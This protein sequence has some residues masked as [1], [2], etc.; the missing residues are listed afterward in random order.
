MKCRWKRR[1]GSGGHKN[2]CQSDGKVI[3][4]KLCQKTVKGL[5]ARIQCFTVIRSSVI[6]KNNPVRIVEEVS[7]GTSP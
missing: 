2:K 4:A 7:I 5:P 6:L 3:P 1:T